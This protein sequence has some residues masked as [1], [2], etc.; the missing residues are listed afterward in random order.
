MNI[1]KTKIPR[2]LKRVLLADGSFIYTQ[3][4]SYKKINRFE[5]DSSNIVSKT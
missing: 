5:A 3:I 2:K 1:K 4:F